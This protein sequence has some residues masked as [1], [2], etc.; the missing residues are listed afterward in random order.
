VPTLIETFS[1][2][3]I[4]QPVQAPGD[5][6]QDAVAWGP[7]L[8][9]RA[10]AA[11][12]IKTSDKLA[13][14]YDADLTNGRELC[15]G[16]S[17][18]AFTTDAD[19]K[20]YYAETAAAGVRGGPWNTSPIWKGGIFDPEDLFTDPSPV[21]QVDTFTPGGTIEVGD[22]FT[23]TAT[24]KDGHTAAVS[25]TAT[26][27]TAA[28]VAAGLVAAWNASTDPLHTGITATGTVTV[29]LTADNA[30]TAFT[31]TGTTTESD[32][33]AADAQTFSRAATTANAGRSFTDILS[34]MNGRVLQNGYIYIP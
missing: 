16:F 13:Y 22:I 34:D 27:T 8:T 3:D 30:G 31:V 12:G 10:G 17:M 4:L 24:G 5:A 29:I 15:V 11:V 1:E 9:V 28:N 20:V 2:A 33:S 25:F 32:G 19:G 26:A 18:Y 14:P 23:L 21:A 6:R 7:S